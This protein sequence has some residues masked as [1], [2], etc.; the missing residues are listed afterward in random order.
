MKDENVRVAGGRKKSKKK[1]T[2]EE[3]QTKQAQA[4]EI[5]REAAKTKKKEDDAQE[6]APAA[7]VVDPEK[8]SQAIAQIIEERA[9]RRAREIMDA[10]V[11]TIRKKIG[12]AK[13][14]R[15]TAGN[16]EYEK[17][18]C[19][20]LINLF[21]GWFTLSY[22]F[23]VKN[24]DPEDTE[25]DFYVCSQDVSL[26]RAN[27][28]PKVNQVIKKQFGKTVYGFAIIAPSTAFE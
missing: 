5:A 14:G 11:K 4:K 28:R 23:S 9:E 2:D 1:L 24:N 26:L 19:E 18:S 7:V 8:E 27:E 17:F 13:R 3:K 25:T 21:G 16:R 22:L 6:A 12:E 15:R 10:K 20:Q